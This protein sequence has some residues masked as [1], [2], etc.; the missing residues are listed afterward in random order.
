[1]GSTVG[2]DSDKKEDRG[3]GKKEDRGEGT[4]DP[5][6]KKGAAGRRGMSVDEKVGETIG[7]SVAAIFGVSW[8]RKEGEG[9]VEENWEGK[10]V[11]GKI[12][13]GEGGGYGTGMMG[14][15]LSG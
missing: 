14:S 3:E 9:Y 15:E 6:E 11:F 1:M 7:W 2:E 8:E 13:E 4:G 5:V 12:T 10:V